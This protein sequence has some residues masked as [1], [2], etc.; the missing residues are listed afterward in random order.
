ML[1]FHG[2]VP[3]IEKEEPGSDDIRK[4]SNLA[5]SKAVKDSLQVYI[6]LLEALWEKRK[7]L[8]DA[9]RKLTKK[10]RYKQTY[11]IIR[12]VPGIGWFTAIRLVLEW[13]EDLTRFVNTRKIAGFVGL[14]GREHSTGET[15]RRGHL[16]GLGHRRS[17]SW[18]VEC[19][20]TAK[21][22]D[23]VLLEKYTHVLQNTGSKKKAIVATARKMVGRLLHC[24]TTGQPYTVGLIAVGCEVKE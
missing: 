22:K 14:A 6:D 5:M 23:P 3:V 18:L 7:L 19:A 8:R 11:T 2:I 10:D 9:L 1:D 15:V 13:G 24:V 12:S 20:W 4:L 17:R 21:R 16:S